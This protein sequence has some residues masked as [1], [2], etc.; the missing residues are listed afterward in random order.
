M[1][2]PKGAFRHLWAAVQLLRSIED[3]LTELEISN[4][5]PVYDAMLRLDFLAQK[6]VPYSCSSFLRCSDVAMMESP[7]WNRPSLRYS[8]ASQ[9]DN[10]AAE[11]YRFIQ[12]VCSHNKLSRVIWGSWCPAS[13]RPSRDEL[14]GFHS[15]MLLWKANSPATFA[16]CDGL[17]NIEAVSETNIE[18]L[19]IPPPAAH[20]ACSDTALN[21]AMYNAYLGCALAM[22]ATTDDDTASIERTAFRLVYQN[23]CISAGLVEEHKR[24]EDP[25]KPCDAID[26]GITT[27]LHHGLRRCY[28]RAWQKWTVQALRNIGREG[29]ANGFTSANTLE[30]MCQLEARVNPAPTEDA[31]LGPIR[32]RLIPLLMP[33][34]DS[35]RFLSFYLRYG[36]MIDAGDERVMRVIAKATWRQ[37]IDGGLYDLKMDIYDQ[38]IAGDY[39]APERPEAEMLFSSWRD[40]VEKGWHGYLAT[41]IQEG[42]LNKQFSSE[43]S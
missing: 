25:Y 35:D 20:F 18:S 27:W 19:T 29:L 7:F 24:F 33:R 9:S 42:F 15:E 4:M 14:I 39:F 10:V 6:L 28:S 43:P 2:N 23:L 41:E 34:G 36:T 8:G 17:E 5:V 37:E 38:T 1:E 40:E 12:L 3:G 16:P 30:I 21:V 31:Y 13:E 32:E 22:I 26:T 11:R